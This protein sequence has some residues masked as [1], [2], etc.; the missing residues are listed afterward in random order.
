MELNKRT[1]CKSQVPAYFHV[2]YIET[3][4]RYFHQ[5]WKF[6][7]YSVFC[8]NV[9]TLNVWTHVV[10]T[11]LMTSRIYQISVI[12]D[13]YDPYT[14]PLLTA[15]LSFF[16]TFLASSIAHMFSHKSKDVNCCMF[17]VDYA[18]IGLFGFGAVLNHHHYSVNKNVD[19]TTQWRILL[20][21]SVLAILCCVCG[22]ISKAV[23]TNPL[24]KHRIILPAAG[25]GLL[26]LSSITPIVDRILNFETTGGIY[27]HGFQILNMLATGFFFSAKLPER[28]FPGTFDFIGN[29]HQIFHLLMIQASVSH[30]DGVIWDMLFHKLFIRLPRVTPSFWSTFGLA[31]VIVVVDAFIIQRFYLHFKGK[32]ACHNFFLSENNNNTDQK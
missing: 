18:C 28:F 25:V 20:T 11:L 7:L 5:P 2:P 14:W 26:Y 10:G 22:A 8:N 12:F 27:H 19:S 1:L 24:S 16:A 13:H 31:F 9:E 6:Y 32:S 30:V 23:I 4:Y 15:L 21:S 29:S 3:G 17:M